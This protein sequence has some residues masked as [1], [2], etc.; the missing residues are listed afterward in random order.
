MARRFLIA[1][2]LLL[3]FQTQLQAMSRSELQNY[4]K[5]EKLLTEK[6]YKHYYKIKAKLKHTPLY[7]YL[8]YREIAEN[9][10]GF[11]Q[12]T[13]LA[14]LTKNKASFWDNLLSQKLAVYY[15]KQRNWPLFLRYY[16]GGLG[17]EG[18]CY[19][20]QAEYALN[21]GE[22]ALSDF[23]A[24]W[25]KQTRLPKAC[26]SFS[27]IWNLK[28]KPATQVIAQKAYHLALAGKY[29]TAIYW[30]AK[31]KDKAQ[32]HFYRLW[33][34]SVQKPKKYLDDFVAAFYQKKEFNQAFISIMNRLSRED[35]YYTADLWQSF[36][37]KKWLSARTRNLVVSEI[38]VDFA[39]AHDKL[40]VFWLRQVADQDA[41]DLLWQWRLRTALYRQDFAAYLAWYRK[42]PQNL[43]QKNVWL[44][45]QG[46]SYLMLKKMSQAKAIL[47]PM[48][49][50]RSYYGFLAADI[51]N[52]PYALNEGVYPVSEKAIE[53]MK[54]NRE[55]QAAFDLY[56]LEHPSMSYRLWQFVLRGMSHEKMLA[57]AKLAEDKQIYQLSVY[58]YSA[59]GAVN[60]LKGRFPL[61]FR[62]TVEKAA[63]R[64]KLDPALIYAVMRKESMYRRKAISYA[65]AGGLM[66]LMPT[67]AKYLAKR[68]KLK[69]D[70]DNWLKPDVNILLGAAN[71][72]FMD[73][74]FDDN[75]VLGI[76]AYN[77][78]QGNVA[79]W[80]ASQPMDADIWIDTIPFKQTRDYLKSVLAY[81][82]VYH[83]EISAHRTFR[84][85]G[86]M[87]KIKEVGK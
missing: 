51:L 18:Q 84:L 42:L 24:I 40:A 63:K 82:V 11:E 26:Q 16:K 17:V 59:A 41:S 49:K 67:T 48:A 22:K 60:N 64:F 79:N 30:I 80:L 27:K 23:T 28:Y 3:A 83:A 39:R 61:A 7:P 69:I 78:G 20:L 76:A 1:C 37:Q 50:K 72:N 70:I 58:A 46:R 10:P 66:Q 47:V 77:A 25:L 21:Q 35:T 81:L 9:P 34:K 14:Y 43:Q 12:K 68:Y 8:Q 15:A 55:L 31:L 62:P 32:I 87:L 13:I 2:F 6:D 54:V 19:K 5:A 56:Q 73:Q 45:W 86:L 4:Q 71:L 74:L 52:Q 44:Y 36:K 29:D 33:K 65:G 75:K 38:A 57:A 53:S 85:P